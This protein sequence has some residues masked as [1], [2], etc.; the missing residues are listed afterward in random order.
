M[1]RFTRSEKF[2]YAVDAVVANRAGQVKLLLLSCAIFVCLSGVAEDNVNGD[3][4]GYAEALWQSWLYMA[5]PGVQSGAPGNLEGR[6]VALFISL[7]G[8]VFFA[9]IVGFVTDA[10]KEKMDS[11]K[12]GRSNVVESGHT[13]MIGWTP[14]SVAFIK[15]ICDANS[16]DGG[17]TI[18]VLTERDKEELEVG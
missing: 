13:V 12:K 4:N 7:G 15:E 10:V 16:S 14:F 18:V 3:E 1:P 2:A 17:G 9:V 6:A 5:D 11:L 8:I